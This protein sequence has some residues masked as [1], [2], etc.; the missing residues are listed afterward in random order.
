MVIGKVDTSDEILGVLM[1]DM[2]AA[3]FILKSCGVAQ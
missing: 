1:Q 3:I 2:S